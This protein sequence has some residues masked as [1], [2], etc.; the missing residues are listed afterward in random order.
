[1]TGEL[2]GQLSDS[3]LYKIANKLRIETIRMVYNVQSGHIGGP[4]SAAEII[5]VLYWC[6]LKYKPT[7]PLW[8]DRDRFVLS[9]G[10]SCPVVYAA[11]ARLGFFPSHHLTT[12]RQFGSLLQGHPSMKHTPGIDM[13]TGSLGQGLSAACGMALGAKHQNKNFHVYTLM[14]DGEQDEGLVWEAALFAHHYRLGNLTAIIDFNGLQLDG[15]NRDV[16]SLEPLAD[17]WKAFGWVVEECNGHDIPNLRTAIKRVQAAEHTPG[18]VIAHTVKG[19]GVS[20]MENVCEW[21]GK[22]PSEEQFKQAMSELG[23]SE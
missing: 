4:L 11:L 20:F 18:M 14:S 8:P 12:L 6:F 1:M 10:H 5:T 3:E 17:K 16:M 7:N 15:F 13:S 19:K 21:H 2:S 23:E 9:K 22:A